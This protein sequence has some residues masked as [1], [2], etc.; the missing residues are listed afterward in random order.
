MTVGQSPQAAGPAPGTAQRI[1]DMAAIAQDFPA[2]VSDRADL[3]QP[4]LQGDGPGTLARLAAYG[5]APL[6]AEGCAIFLVPEDSPAVLRFEAAHPPALQ[7][8]WTGSL[9]PI[10]EFRSS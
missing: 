9:V 5:C 7:A 6:P 8:G 1:A 3:L 4:A 10:H 2:L